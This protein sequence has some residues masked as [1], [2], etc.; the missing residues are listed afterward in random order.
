M[1]KASLGCVDGFGSSKLQTAPS[2][3]DKL[4]IFNTPSNPTPQL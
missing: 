2:P 4:G 1:G 3:F